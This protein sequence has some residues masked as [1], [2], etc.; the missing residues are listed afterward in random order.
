[1]FEDRERIVVHRLQTHFDGLLHLASSLTR[2]QKRVVQLA[3]DSVLL[4]GCFLVAMFLRFDSWAFLD[5][6]HVLRPILLAIPLT[7]YVFARMGLYRAVVRY[8]SGKALK[9]VAQGAALSGLFLL[10]SSQAFGWPI[11]RSVPFIYVLLVLVG[12]GGVRFLMRALFSRAHVAEKTRVLIYGAGDSGRQLYSSLQEGREYAPVVFVD[13][14]EELHGSVIGGLRVY[15]PDEVE[16]LVQEYRIGVI[17]LAIPSASRSTRAQILAALEPL[18]VQVRTI[19]GMVDIVTG[20][21]KI[22]EIREVPIED[23]LGRDP[24]PPRQD[25]L[26]ANIRDKVVLVTGAGGSI[27]SELCRQVLRLHPRRLV[28]LELS[29]YA[30]YAIDRDL[31]E[32]ARREALSVSV[33]PLLG[34]VQDGERVASLLRHFQV[35]TVYHAA[36]YKHVPLVEFNVVEGIRN[37]VF[38]SLAVARAAMDAGVQAFILVSTDKAVRPTNFMGASKRMAEL[39]CQAL[40]G[41]HSATCFSMVRF[42]NVLGSS[43]SVIPLFQQQIASGGPITVTHPDIT[44][45]FMTIPEAAQLVIQAGAMARGGDVFVLDMGEPTRIVDLATRMARLSGLQPVVVGSDASRSER[46]ANDIDIVFTGLRPGEK[47][48]EELLI[49]DGAQRTEHAR[50]MTATEVSLPLEELEPLLWE[51]RAACDVY[52]VQRVRDLLCRAPTGYRPKDPIA[53]PMHGTGF[54]ADALD[55]LPTTANDSRVFVGRA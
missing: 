5:K 2:T 41:E 28:L 24:V 33:T 8:V 46:A 1:M 11:P 38:G 52:D 16:R 43:G 10:I 42:G 25:L 19:P 55:S 7:L 29:E 17:L 3:V 47:L 53:D 26:D 31:Q 45:Y 36:A 20:R 48:Y 49:A 50:I 30:L 22:S 9:T 18:P 35:D 23:L 51:L 32:I 14:N 15:R 37:N 27:G 44:R 21:A 54:D 12:V 6:A 40:A 13:D 34:S 39:A 4:L